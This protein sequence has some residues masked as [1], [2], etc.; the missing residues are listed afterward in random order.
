[1]SGT[2]RAASTKARFRLSPAVT[3]P[4]LE[5]IRTLFLAYAASLPVDLGYQGFD[6][7]LA[8]LPGA[9]APPFGSLLLAS[10]P[11][12]HRVGCVALRPLAES[13]RCE[14]KRLYVVPEA[15]GY[16]LGR[17]LVEAVLAE[18][19]RLG[20]REMVLDTLPSML[21]ALSLYRAA[22]FL[23]IDPYYD[24]PLVETMFLSRPLST[25]ARS[26]RT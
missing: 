22:G 5:H 7:E 1:M 9:Y 21:G 19:V 11:L 25:W 2:P 12:G 17:I 20:H 23:P 3:K 8:T 10:D 26:A 15:R 13:G 18:G 14:M 4:E 16:G 24:T 6:A